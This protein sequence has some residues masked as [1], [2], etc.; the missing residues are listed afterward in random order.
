MTAAVTGA[1]Q[2]APG[3]G[4]GRGELKGRM[5]STEGR[6][7]WLCPPLLKLLTQAL[8]FDVLIKLPF[9]SEVTLD[10]E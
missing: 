10:L 1:L 6:K 8:P 4:H 2:V 5:P 9:G 3:V 7:L